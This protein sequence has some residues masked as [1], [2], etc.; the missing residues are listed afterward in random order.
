M[1]EVEFFFG[2][3]FLFFGKDIK[4]CLNMVGKIKDKGKIETISFCLI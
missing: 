2:F 4:Y 3:F 1:N